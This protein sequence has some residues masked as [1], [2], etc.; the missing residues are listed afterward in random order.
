MASRCKPGGGVKI[1]HGAQEENFHRRSDL[2][3]FLEQQN[4]DRKFYP[5][6]DRG[7]LLSR[8]ATVFRG[9]EQDGY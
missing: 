2:V 3:R 6:P 5:I 1:G 8:D 4:W 7:C 9:V